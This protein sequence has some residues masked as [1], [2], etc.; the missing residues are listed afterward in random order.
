MFGGMN[1]ILGDTMLSER[2][3]CQFS[4]EIE[5]T[6]MKGV[7]IGV[8]E[9]GYDC[10]HKIGRDEISWGLHSNGKL[11]HKGHITDYCHELK[12]KT[13]ITVTLKR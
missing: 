1:T 13:V 10:K 7:R 6:G 11:Y 5:N 4:M 3:N 9:A 12:S 2:G 8:A